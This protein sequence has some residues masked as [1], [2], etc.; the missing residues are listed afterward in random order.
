MKLRIVERME[1]MLW[2]IHQMP[3][4]KVVVRVRNLRA[5][6]KA[7]PIF[8]ICPFSKFFVTRLSRFR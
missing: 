1:R 7:W 5:A 4:S 6:D 8:R 2:V 3:K